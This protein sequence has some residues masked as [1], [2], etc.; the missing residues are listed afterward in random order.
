MNSPAVDDQYVWVVRNGFLL[1]P[2][3]DYY[4]SEDKLSV[5]ILGG[6]DENDTVET[7]HFSNTLLRNKYGWRQFKDILN[8]THYKIINGKEDIRLT[9]DLHW[10]SK[11]IILE[12]TESL[13]KPNSQDGKPGVIFVEGERIEYFK[14]DKLKLTQLRR[15]TLGTGVKNT[16]TNGTEIYNQSATFTMPYKDET[17]TT[18]FTAT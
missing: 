8:R 12:N 3:V 6:L 16:Y 4:L 7:I 13:P 17:L 18:V 15:G 9:H 1:D 5:K 14:K 10:Y 11:E 2:S